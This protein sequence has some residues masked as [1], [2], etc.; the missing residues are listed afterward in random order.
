MGISGFYK[1]LIESFPD[2]SGM[3]QEL[4]EQK[5]ICLYLDFNGNI[6]NSI[7]KVIEKYSQCERINRREMEEEMQVEIAKNIEMLVEKIRPKLLFIATDGV[8]PRAKMQQQRLRRYNNVLNHEKRRVFDTNAISPGTLFMK[9]L[10]DYMKKFI[11]EL[12]QKYKTKILYSDQSYPGEGEHKIINFIKK[13]KSKN[14]SHVIHGLDADL[15]MLSLTTGLDN[16]YLL[17]EKQ[18]FEHKNETEEDRKQHQDT[19]EREFNYLPINKVKEYYW[20]YIN[21][22]KDYTPYV[23]KQQF[24]KDFVFMCYFLGNDFLP[25]LKVI[26]VH[27]GGIELLIGKYL[28]EIVSNDKKYLLDNENNI[29]QDFLMNMLYDIYM[30]EEKY[31]EKN[32]DKRRDKIVKYNQEGWRERFYSFYYRNYDDR[33]INGIC[34]N[35]MQMLK[36]VTKYYFEGCPNWDFYYK[37]PCPPCFSDLYRFM[38]N[39]NINDFFFPRSKPYTQQQQLMVILPPQSSMLIKREYSQLMKTELRRYY[40]SRFRLDSI[41][42]YARWQWR[43]MLPILND[44][45]LKELVKN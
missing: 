7:A 33:L 14:V 24:M 39:N 32:N 38:K 37:H 21:E 19:V 25:H 35:Y 11:K 6:H 31:I 22:K 20:N 41:D 27:R 28:E 45:K 36:W 9:R 34:Y 12:E 17:R 1:H 16:V 2:L 4:I 29:N 10:S 23:T 13:V 15:I 40:P 26:N 42:C 30:N 8:A 43:P 44:R 3:I 18:I 5:N